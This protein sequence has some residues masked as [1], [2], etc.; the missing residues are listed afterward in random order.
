MKL[1]LNKYTQ[2]SIPNPTPAMNKI[3]LDDVLASNEKFPSAVLSWGPSDFRDLKALNPKSPYDVSWVNLKF[4]MAT[5]KKVPCRI[6]IENQILASGAKIPQAKEE[7]DDITNVTVQFKSL[8]K[9]EIEGG[10]YVPGVKDTSEAQ[11]VEDARIAKNIDDYVANNAKLIKV[12]H[13]LNQSFIK[14]TDEIIKTN[15]KDLKFTVKKDRK[16][17]SVRIYAFPQTTRFDAEAKEDIP[18]ESPIFRIKLAVYKKDGRIGQWNSFKDC[19]KPT[20]FDARKMTKKNGFKPV[21]A[22]V[23][24]GKKK[25]ELNI[26]NV[27]GFITR[28]SLVSGVLVFDCVTISKSGIS[29]GNKFD[30]MYIVRHKSLAAQEKVSVNV[31]SSMRG[32]LGSDDEGSDVELTEKDLKAAKG[33]AAA[34]DSDTDEEEQHKP[35]ADNTSDGEDIDQPDDPPSE[36]EEPPPPAEVKKPKRAPPKKKQ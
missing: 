24:E 18:L 31:I 20:V 2:I 5:G 3:T 14:V 9:E 4:I 1:L 12:L 25:V 8:T 27:G 11:E 22:Y 6:T 21:P 30:E 19:F 10:D 33:K 23:R 34:A 17:E 13:I 32:A 26:K 36:P 7:G 15:P 16:A 28:K 35:D 29:L